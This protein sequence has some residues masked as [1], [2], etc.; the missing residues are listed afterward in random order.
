[1]QAGTGFIQ[2]IPKKYE[3]LIV[4]LLKKKLKKKTNQ[5]NQI[6]NISLCMKKIVCNHE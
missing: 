2:T 5:D 6:G 4:L 1:M 3:H